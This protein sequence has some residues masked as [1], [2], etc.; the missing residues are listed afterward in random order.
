MGKFIQICVFVFKFER[1]WEE[2]G[3]WTNG[4]KSYA[5]GYFEKNSRCTAHFSSVAVFFFRTFRVSR[6]NTARSEHDRCRWRL[7]FE[8]KA[9]SLLEIKFPTARPSATR[10]R[11]N[12]RE[13]RCIPARRTLHCSRWFGNRAAVGSMYSPVHLLVYEVARSI[14]LDQPAGLGSSRFFRS[15]QIMQRHLT[16]CSHAAR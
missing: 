7:H 1:W 5:S 12:C 4:S 15:A 9:Q 13:I 16:E 10:R 6:E 2:E 14:P 8:R 11:C 3:R